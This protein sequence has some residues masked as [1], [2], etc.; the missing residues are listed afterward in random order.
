MDEKGGTN[1][2][3]DDRCLTTQQIDGMVK[4]FNPAD[5]T[6][7]AF[8]YVCAPR[9]S[10]KSTLVEDII[11]NYR[12]KNKIDAC[13]LFSKSN[14]G[15]YQIPKQYR[16]R[17][18][19]HLQ[20][21]ID[22]QLRVKKHN[23][24]QKKKSDKVSSKVIV[25][26]DDMLDGNK[27]MRKNKLLSKLST[28]GRH[29]AYKKEHNDLEGNGIMCIC[30]SQDFVGI[31]PVIR[32]NI[33]W[34][35]ATKVPDRNQRKAF[36]EQYLCLKTGRNGLKEAYNAFDVTNLKDFNF[37]CV[38]STCSNRYEYSDYVYKYVAKPKLPKEKWVGT[39]QQW[40][41]NEIEIVW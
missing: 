28:M 37:I 20:S 17:N 36:V 40:R 25:I 16:F 35:F 30:I 33:D 7:D 27:S 2:K 32:R 10:G 19:D 4:E 18:L 31:P 22:I 23:Q 6:N 1:N 14:A 12:K 39:A 38:N 9:R 29:I 15:F 34:A 24:K 26:L 13:F 11:H 5:L 3:E 41:D 8:V 21:I